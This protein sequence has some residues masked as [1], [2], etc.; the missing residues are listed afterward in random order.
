MILTA[1]HNRPQFA[2]PTITWE[3]SEMTQNVTLLWTDIPKDV[4][5]DIEW[6]L[7]DELK[8]VE[9]P[10]NPAGQWFFSFASVIFLV[11]FFLLA[12]LVLVRFLQARA[13][14]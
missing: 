6:R 1:S 11:W 8:S 13:M 3:A 12:G 4:R 14:W 10:V 9:A 2:A 7:S 5:A